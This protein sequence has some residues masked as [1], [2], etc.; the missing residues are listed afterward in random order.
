MAGSPVVL[1]LCKIGGIPGASS[2]YVAKQ[3][4]RCCARNRRASFDSAT[5]QR[6]MIENLL[7]FWPL[8]GFAL[9]GPVD[10]PVGEP[11]GALDDQVELPGEVVDLFLALQSSDDE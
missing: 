2:S 6:R 4:A 3:G 10:G 1:L 11:A 9:Q 8:A 5:D 7:R